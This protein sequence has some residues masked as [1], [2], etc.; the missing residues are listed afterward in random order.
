ME[1]GM[2]KQSNIKSDVNGFSINYYRDILESAKNN[3][4]ELLSI[5][6][7]VLNKAAKFSQKIV[8][9]RHDLDDKPQRLNAIL[10]VEADLGIRSSIYVLV[11]TNTYNFL[12]VPVLQSL[13][14]AESMGFEIGLHSNF[15]EFA[16]LLDAKPDDILAK[17]IKILRCHFQIDGIA[18]HRN[19]D[20]MF[21]SLP[22][23]EEKWPSF[24]KSLSLLYQAY[25]E[26]LFGGF[27][28]VNEGLSPH[29]G[30][31]SQTP[32][33]VIKSGQ[34]LYLSTHPHWWHRIHAFED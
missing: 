2:N 33:E 10:D 19:I 7:Y 23:L 12:S 28:F 31:R 30:W 34:S 16:K 5:R 11:H 18:C 25:D 17:E 1:R 22:Y 4:Y 21:N 9:I 29:L 8:L 20:Y 26:D 3:G 14:H 24:K 13:R 15:V 32:E 27:Q 6:D